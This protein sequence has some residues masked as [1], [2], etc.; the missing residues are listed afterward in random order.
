MTLPEPA[1]ALVFGAHPDDLEMGCAGLI[2][3]LVRRGHRVVAVDCTRGELSTR[4]TVESR[5]KETEAASK[6][7]GI[8]ARENLGLPDGSIPPT[9][10]AR[11][12]VVALI[13]KWRPRLLVAP[14]ARD[15]HPDH[16]NA[17]RLVLESHFLAGVAK[18]PPD[19]PDRLPP[20]RANQ[21]VHYMQ[22]WRFEPS[23]VVDVSEVFEEKMNAIRCYG[24]QFFKDR[25]SEPP[26]NLARKEFLDEL[27]A[28]DRYY[29]MAIGTRYGEPYRLEGPVRLDDPV[30]AWL[31]AVPPTGKPRS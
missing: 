4:G 9:G 30:A 31:D 21:I 7:L 25:T 2:R 3:V 18:F 12:G 14:P 11:N 13:R 1:E 28:R 6:V 24:S 26:T 22:H 20:H 8:V 16:A 5:A 10:A 27:E 15:L 19:V 23:F 17:G 29:G